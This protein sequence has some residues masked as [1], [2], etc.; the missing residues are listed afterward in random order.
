MNELRDQL[1][2]PRLAHEHA[3][4][5]IGDEARARQSYVNALRATRGEVVNELPGRDLRQKIFDQAAVEERDEHGVPRLR[6]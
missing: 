6:G 4:T 1:A 5:A 2:V 3:N